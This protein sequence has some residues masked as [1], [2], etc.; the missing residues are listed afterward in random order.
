MN[1]SI[2]LHSIKSGWSI[3]YILYLKISYVL[4]N[5][6]DTGKMLYFIL[7]FDFC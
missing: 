6:A 2:E 1:F 5:S 7:V 3:V 4:A